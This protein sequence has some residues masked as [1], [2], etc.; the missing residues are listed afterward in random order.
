MFGLCGGAC[1][2]HWE[3]GVTPCPSYK[4]N[5]QDRLDIG[6]AQAGMLIAS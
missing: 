6:A 2:K 5:I 3:E 1:P 4:F